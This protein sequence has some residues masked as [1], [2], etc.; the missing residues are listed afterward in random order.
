ML[1]ATGYDLDF[2]PKSYWDFEDPLQAILANIK[3]SRRREMVRDV[4]TAEGPRREALQEILGDLDSALYGESIHA[5]FTSNLT[6]I[7]GPTWLG[8]EF[9]P[10]S[11]PGETE[12]ARVT[13][14]SST[15][16]VYSVRARSGKRR[17]YY[18]IVDEYQSEWQL[19][20]KSSVRP[21]T[22]RQLIQLIDTATFDNN[23][24]DDLTI[25]IRELNDFDDVEA[26]ADFVIV[27]S[28][29]YPQLEA[30]YTRKEFSW[31]AKTLAEREL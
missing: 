4:L 26:G 20:R 18:S 13:L 12:V 15:Q 28:E 31:A 8:G 14:A 29:I 25:A 19:E 2:R 5:A 10:N 9:L 23:E 24:W 22:M 11:A 17:I 6:R 7:H 21:L 16:D 3:G 1:D 27:S 30:Y